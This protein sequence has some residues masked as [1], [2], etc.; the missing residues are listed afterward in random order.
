MQGLFGVASIDG[1]VLERSEIAAL[2]EAVGANHGRMAATPLSAACADGWAT[3][4]EGDD[5]VAVAGA[6]HLVDR[7]ALGMAVGEGSALELVA[8]VYRTHGPQGLARLRGQFCLAILD[9]RANRLVL[10][11]DRFTTWPIYYAEQRGRITF[12]SRLGG[13]PARLRAEIDLQAILEYLL[14]TVV[15]SPRTPYVGVRKLPPAHMLIAERASL[16]VA[17]YWDMLYSESRN[18][19][20]EDWARRLRTEIESA[21]RRYVV[22]EKVADVGAFLSGGTDSSTIAGMIKA[23]TGQRLRTF[24]IGYAEPGYDELEYARAAAAW[25][26]TA[27][28]EHL[29]KPVEAL[30]ALPHIV[31][32]YEEPFGNASALPTYSCARLARDNGVKVLFAGDGGDEL[33]AG[34]ER[35]RTHKIFGLYQRLPKPLRQHVSDPLL[36]SLP[37]RLP[38]LGQ[39]RRYVRRSNIPN[40]RRFYSYDLMLS[41][42]LESLLTPEFL[43]A[44]QPDHLLA[45]AEA[46][47]NRPA[48]PTTELN[49]M[50]YLDL[51]LAI[52]DNDVRKVSGM[53][54]LAGVE[55]RYPF[56]DAE[57]AE[58]SGRIP[59][60]LKL[61]GLQKRYIFKQ[62]LADFLPPKVLNKPKHGFGAP[63]AVWMKHDAQWR[64]F[65]A[66]V[67]H[68][69]RT[70]E[71]GYFTPSVLE[72]LWSQHQGEQ[73]S[74]YGDMMWPVLML[75]LWHREHVDVGRRE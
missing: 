61:R 48:S 69:R 12:A 46:H 57:L 16:N 53:A 41:A 55:V 21:V 4:Y 20:A 66:D 8:A 18:G 58:F 6:A 67:L 32:Y 9:Q 29:L 15:P 26:G 28:H 70:R 17:P 30:D 36:S 39:A 43:R 68:D 72:D 7:E 22:A 54:E 74:Y 31:S 38:L 73:S 5:G 10:A 59:T 75:E 42:P 35:Y 62:A 11:T 47:F 60:D 52:A 14:Y 63:I 71:R 25:F 3:L 37:D 49:R 65:V 27:Q 56:L 19:N 1:A 34:N 24:S 23:I 13:L 33:F 50:M 45:T 51:K 64:E 2:A 44:V 40:P